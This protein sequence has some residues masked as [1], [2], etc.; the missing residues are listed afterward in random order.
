MNTPTS[1]RERISAVR[2]RSR[3]RRNAGLAIRGAACAGLAICISAFFV[4]QLVA[5]LHSDWWHQ[6]P[7]MGYNTAV[8]LCSLAALAVT[9]VVAATA[10]IRNL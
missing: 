4:M 9:A 7:G 2:A 8:L 5:V 6:I 10:W 1:R 3:R